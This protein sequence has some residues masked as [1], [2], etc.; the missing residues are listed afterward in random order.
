MLKLEPVKKYKSPGYPDK[1]IVLEN[2][3]IIKTFPERWKG[4]LFVGLTFSSIALMIL[5][6]C[7][8]PLPTPGISPAP[9]YFTEEDAYNIVIEE[10]EKYGVVFDKEGL[11]LT[12]VEFSLDKKAWWVKTPRSYKVNVQLDGYDKEKGIA[13]EF[14]S[15]NDI[16][17]YNDNYAQISGLGNRHVWIDDYS[18]KL[19]EA[20]KNKNEEIYFNAFYTGDQDYIEGYEATLK[21][22]VISFMEWLKSQGVI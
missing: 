18:A 10:A 3:D 19:E 16:S 5:S 11:Q 14:L 12:D 17:E 6:G 2:P 1:R 9:V 15:K 22:Q 8:R 21:E 4:K 20:I 7:Q 13:F